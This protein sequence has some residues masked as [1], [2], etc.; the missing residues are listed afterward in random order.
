MPN[1]VFRTNQFS[2]SFAQPEHLFA[3]VT[4][5]ASGAPTIVSG[6]GMGISSI[7]RNS[8]GN[9]TINLSHAY[10]ATLMVKHVF[11]DSSAPA[12]PSMF[13]LSDLSNSSSSPSIVI[14][15]NASGTATDP[16]SGE[17]V[18]LEISLQKSSVRY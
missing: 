8:A 5:G 17:E 2:Y 13:V 3:K 11:V 18:L 10:F 16:A 9:F 14:E 15:F 7:V 1:P 6:T 4:F 12:S